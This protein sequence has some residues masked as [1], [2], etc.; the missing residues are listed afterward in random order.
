QISLYVNGVQEGSKTLGQAFTDSGIAELVFGTNILGQ[1]FLDGL[2][3]D[4]EL[5]N[6]ALSPAEVAQLYQRGTAGQCQPPRSADNQ[7]PRVNAGADATIRSEEH[8]SEL[9]SRVD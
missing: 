6:R 1:S 5:Y 3:D 8:T 2:L 9:Q 4:V 7:A